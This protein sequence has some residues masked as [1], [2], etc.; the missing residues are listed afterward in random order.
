MI[1]SHLRFPEV[2]GLLISCI[3]IGLSVQGGGLNAIKNAGAAMLLT[4]EAAARF[5]ARL[6]R[7][8]KMMTRSS[9]HIPELF[10]KG[11]NS[12]WGIPFRAIVDQHIGSPVLCYSPLH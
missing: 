8:G 5:S 4:E 6:L 2:I 9:G 1:A 10:V 3:I 11:L 7:E 12:Q